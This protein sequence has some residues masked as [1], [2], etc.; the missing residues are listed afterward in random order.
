MS[1]INKNAKI[2]EYLLQCQEIQNSPLYFNFINAKDGSNQVMTMTDV[3]STLRTY[4]DG[5]IR[6]RYLF[7]IITFK[8]ISENAIVKP[9]GTS[10]PYPDENIEDM[11][12]V[13]TLID[14]VNEQDDLCNYPDFGTDCI[15]DSIRTTTDTP[16]L[17]GINTELI[18]PLAM[19]SISIQVEYIDIS[20]QI[21]N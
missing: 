20:K 12:D 9:V 18:P 21:W 15:I 7:N 3:T 4:I 10:G 11:Q 2:I 8:S 19:Y 13:Q 6:K 14:W 1:T 5:S 16:T 17:M